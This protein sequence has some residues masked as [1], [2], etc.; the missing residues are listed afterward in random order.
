MNNGIADV[1]LSLVQ[2]IMMVQCSNY[3]QQIKLQKVVC[4]IVLLLYLKKI[5]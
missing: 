3:I 5:L 2:L 4:N 1:Y